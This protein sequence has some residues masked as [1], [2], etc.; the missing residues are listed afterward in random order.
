MMTLFDY[1]ITEVT[2]AF[3][4]NK[5]PAR[6][7]LMRQFLAVMAGV[8]AP[9][10]LKPFLAVTAK[11]IFTGSSQSPVAVFKIGLACGMTVGVN[12]EMARKENDPFT[13]P[14]SYSYGDDL[15]AVLRKFMEE[16][17]ENKKELMTKFIDAVNHATEPMKQLIS[18][19]VTELMA[20]GHKPEGVLRMA[21]AYGFTLGILLENERNERKGR[22][23]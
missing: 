9:A 14:K 5:L 22:I 19:A 23:N 13:E 3:L 20:A 4:S 2:R 18:D 21:A 12:L 8:A 16:K 6:Q 1:D 10:A 15:R 17:L 7:P 11:K